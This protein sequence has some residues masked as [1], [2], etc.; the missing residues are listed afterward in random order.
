MKEFWTKLEKNP[1]FFTFFW[2]A[3]GSFAVWLIVEYSGSTLLY[4]GTGVLGFL[5]DYIDSRYARAAV[6]QNTTYSYFILILIFVIFA[7]G[8]REISSKISTSL[9]EPKEER[10]ENNVKPIPKWVPYFFIFVKLLIWFYLLLALLF[11]AGESIV[12]NASSDFK[13]HVRIVAPYISDQEK[14]VILSEWSQMGSLEDYNNIYKKL[15]PIAK[16]HKLVLKSNQNY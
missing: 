15:I 4:L 8:W 7:V 14:E 9:K 5:T 1:R 6:L 13:Q 2:G 3:L 11:L 16:E 10:D 12:L